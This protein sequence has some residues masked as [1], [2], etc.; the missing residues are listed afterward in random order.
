MSLLPFWDLNVSVALLSIQ[1]QKALGLNVLF[2]K[3]CGLKM[4]KGVWNDRRV[5]N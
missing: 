2:V 4:N 1:G 5:S 3:I